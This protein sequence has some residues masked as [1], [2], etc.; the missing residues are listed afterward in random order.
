MDVL[1]IIFFIPC[2]LVG[3]GVFAI[4]ALFL[5]DLVFDIIKDKRNRA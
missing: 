4:L 1:Y 2:F 5:W 3:W